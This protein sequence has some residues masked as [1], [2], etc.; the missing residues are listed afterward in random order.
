MTDGQLRIP[1]A[2]RK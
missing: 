2:T 1:H